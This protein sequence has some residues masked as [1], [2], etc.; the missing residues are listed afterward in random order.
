MN[1]RRALVA[2]FAALFLAL[3][4]SC[5]RRGEWYVGHG[6][7]LI[8]V[9]GLR[10]DHLGYAGYDRDTSPHVDTLAKHAV[11]FDGA[12][13]LSPL[14]FPS[15]ATLLTGCDPNMSRRRLPALSPS[16]GSDAWFV[17]DTLPSLAVEF[18]VAGYSTAA[19]VDTT[20]FDANRGIERGFQ[21]VR[22]VESEAERL[23][24]GPLE[25][26]A[27]WVRSRRVDED[28]FC[29]VQLDDLL[30]AFERPHPYW[31][32]F[33][34]PRPELDWIPPVGAVERNFHAIPPSRWEGG[35]IPMARYE[36]RYDGAV[37]RF[38]DAVQSLF[39]KVEL[40]GRFKRT[41]VC[42][43][44]A[45]GF[46]FGENGL[47]L[48]H[49]MCAPQD[50]HVPF[51]LRPAIELATTFPEGARHRSLVTLADV[52][53]TLLELSGVPI[54]EGVHGESLVPRLAAVDDDALPD[55]L[56]ELAKRRTVVVSSGLFFGAAVYGDEL[57]V[58]N[59]VPVIGAVPR[60][61]DQWLGRP[62]VEAR[63]VR[64]YDWRDPP[65]DQLLEGPDGPPGSEAEVA[66]LEAA[67][68]TWFEHFLVDEHTKFWG[69]P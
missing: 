36:A 21:V 39:D 12:L 49:G 10:A 64:V 40:G 41:T 22:R 32:G 26:A 28:W 6:V 66:R 25:L 50:V 55:D 60:M 5:G 33:F 46:E 45:Y 44:G 52:A 37:R 7:L 23:D 63:E 57:V 1:H 56:R 34:E 61:I 4:P 30:R 51:L 9:D 53:P 16:V 59:V 11:S 15:L 24:R 42:L 58:D 54:P 65:P 43:V 2:A 68:A 69:A 17:K 48:D 67:L 20:A 31:D 14:A 8:A 35:T 13:A 38:D 27:E 3:V 19:F 29:F 62:P 47:L 18:A